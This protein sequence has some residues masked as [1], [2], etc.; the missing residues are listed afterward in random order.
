MASDADLVYG[1]ARAA[2]FAEAAGRGSARIIYM[3]VYINSIGY[4]V[5]SHPFLWNTFDSMNTQ[6]DINII[7]E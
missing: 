6:I 4:I 1:S 5:R 7:I 3:Y 2:K